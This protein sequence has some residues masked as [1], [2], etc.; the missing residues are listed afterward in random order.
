[1]KNLHILETKK[2]V[3]KFFRPASDEFTLFLD[4][5]VGC[6]SKNNFYKT[7][8]GNVS[9]SAICYDCASFKGN[10]NLDNQNFVFCQGDFNP[11]FQEIIGLKDYLEP[12]E[13]SIEEFWIKK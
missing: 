4:D 9:I 11:I 1:M 2:I 6:P 3:Q 5:S 10:F 12:I 7:N 8:Q 13:Q